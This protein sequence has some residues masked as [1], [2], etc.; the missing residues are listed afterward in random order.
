MAYSESK[1]FGQSELLSPVEAAKA[2]GIKLSTIRAWILHRRIPFVKL[3]GKLIKF[4]RADIEKFITARLVPA[5][6]EA[7]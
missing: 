2:L 6:K 4:R 5:E 3:G 7:R 1:A